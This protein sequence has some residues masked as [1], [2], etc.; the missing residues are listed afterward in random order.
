M[1]ETTR[2]LINATQAI[3]KNLGVKF[4]TQCNLTRPVDGG[5]TVTLINGRT[6]WKCSTCAKKQKPSG[7]F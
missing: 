1:N 2:E 3:A 5:K 4:C 6:R 7:V